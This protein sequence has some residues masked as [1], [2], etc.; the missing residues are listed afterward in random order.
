MERIKTLKENKIVFLIGLIIVIWLALVYA[1][2]LDNGLLELIKCSNEINYFDIKITDSSI[3]TVIVFIAIY[4]FG[5]GTYISTRKN[6]RKQ[7]EH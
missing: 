2:H 3:H 6:Y 7:E 1:P 5:I 4:F